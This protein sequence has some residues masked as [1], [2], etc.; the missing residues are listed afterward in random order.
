MLYCSIIHTDMFYN[1]TT[2]PNLLQEFTKHTEKLYD[3]ELP[4]DTQHESAM[5][6]GMLYDSIILMHMQYEFITITE[7]QHCHTEV[8]DPAMQTDIL[9]QSIIQETTI[10]T[11]IK[12][13]STSI[14]SPL[15][16][17]GACV[18]AHMNTCLHAF[19]CLSACL[20]AYLSACVFQKSLSS[21][22]LRHSPSYFGGQGLS[23]HPELADSQVS[24][25]Q[26][27][28][29]LCFSWAGIIG[30]LCAAFYVSDG[31]LN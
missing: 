15:C 23:L 16:P 7:M 4:A 14:T 3:S 10:Q 28:S 2:Q 25:L 20:P 18:C 30:T 29:C 26:G 24:E 31:E 9:Y 22:F 21:V 19:T 12:L 27:S 6:I 8:Y 13:T 11:H 1:T 17:C 5:Q